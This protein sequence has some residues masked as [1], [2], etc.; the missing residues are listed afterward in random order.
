M[1]NGGQT[2]LVILFMSAHVV[3]EVEYELHLKPKLGA[4]LEDKHTQT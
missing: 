2:S 1:K 4:D 3:I